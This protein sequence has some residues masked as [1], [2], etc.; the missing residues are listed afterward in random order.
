MIKGMSDKDGSVFYDVDHWVMV[1]ECT[2]SSL[3]IRES[4]CPFSYLYSDTL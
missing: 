1:T 2:N 4:D 3:Y